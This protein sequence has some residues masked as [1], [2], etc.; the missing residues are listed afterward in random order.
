MRP[1]HELCT[2]AIGLLTLALPLHAQRARCGTPERAPFDAQAGYAFAAGDC[3]YWENTPQPEY[4]PGPVF[5]IPV[6][7]HVI[8]N[9]QGDGFL[10]AATVKEQIDILNEDFGALPGSPGA[11]GADSGIRFH[12]ATVD[13]GGSATSGITYTTNNSWY[14]DSG[15][16][17]SPLAWDTDRYLNIYTNA[18][19]CCY[20]YVPDFPSAGGL[21]GQD[22]DRVV[23]WWE[24]V[25]RDGTPGW[26]LNMGRTAT[27]EVGHYLGLYHVRQRL[28]FAERLRHHRRPH[29]RHEPPG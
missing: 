20:G 22:H 2:L 11:P 8:M 26:P 9:S 27:H 23:L 29:L 5:D 15:N 13:P 19:P 4:D 16:Y 18:P 25:G 1:L 7:F 12:L 14:D 24:A 28:R 21:V 6:V 17:W 3:G 10:D